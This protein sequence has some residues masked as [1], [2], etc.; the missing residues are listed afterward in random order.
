MAEDDELKLHADQL[1]D[2][3]LSQSIALQA[4]LALQDAV[5]AARDSVSMRQVMFNEMM[6]EA[7]ELPLAERLQFLKD[8]YSTH[9]DLSDRMDKIFERVDGLRSNVVGKDEK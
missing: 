4:G 8:L 3:T 1:R 9:A 2:I 5:A 7:K 6:K